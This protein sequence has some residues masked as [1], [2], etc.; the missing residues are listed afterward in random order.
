MGNVLTDTSAGTGFPA[1]VGGTWNRSAVLRYGENPHQQAA[2]YV[3][4]FQPSPGLAQARQLHGKEMSYNNYVDADAAHRAAYDHGDRPTVAIIKHANPCGIAVGDDIADAHR[5]AHACDPVSAYGGIIATNRPVTAAMAERSSRTSSP[6][7]WWRRRSTTDALEILTREEEPAAARGG[8]PGRRWGRDPADLRWAAD[9]GP[10]RDRRV[11]RGQGRQRDRRRPVALAAGRRLRRPRTRRWPT[12]SSPG[13]RCR[14]VKSNAI[15][16]A[17]DGAS[18]GVGMGQVN[19]VDSCQ[20]AV[21]A[22]GGAGRGLGGR[23]RRVLPV[24]RRPADPARR[25]GLGD[26]AAGRLG[27]RRRGHRGR[28]R[29]PA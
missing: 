29:R 22:G 23:V 21:D 11:G 7:W 14:A 1:W 8:R 15:L 13:G 6:R 5:K 16:L 10:R 24:R 19:R 26:R 18:V 2:L 12:W 9:A 28:H 4:G 25:R 27:P 20:L 17:S 3:N